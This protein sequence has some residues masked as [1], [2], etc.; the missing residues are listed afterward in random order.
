[1][2]FSLLLFSAGR[3]SVW[4]QTT[5]PADGHTAREEAEGKEI[6]EKLQN[7]DLECN[8]LSDDNFG[9]IGEYVMGQMMG[10]S[11]EAMNTMIIQMMG[12]QGEEHM[13]I[14]M[15]KRLSECQ[16][17]AQFPQDRGG[18][19]P[20]MGS[21]G[22]PQVRGGGNP[23]MGGGGWNTMMGWG[24]FGIVGWVTMLA[25]WFLLILGV[26]ALI[27]YLSGVGKTRDEDKPASPA[28][29]SPLE[30]LKERYARGEMNKKEFEEMKKDLR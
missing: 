21:A 6:W 16:T 30:I 29:R 25:F 2:T 27:R 15:G 18:F 19:M 3:T 5:S 11:H 9:A 20:M 4:A 12:E 24:G 1:M 8:D 17:D 7:K 28:G 10:G 14:V 22:S 23:M 13:H 26:V